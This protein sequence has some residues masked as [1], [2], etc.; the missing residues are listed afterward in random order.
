M[1]AIISGIE[2]IAMQLAYKYLNLDLSK[3]QLKIIKHPLSQAII[4]LFMFYLTC[5]NIWIS[6]LLVLGYQL[7]I[8]ILLNE[9]H[10]LN[11]YSKHWLIK[12]GFKKED[13]VQKIKENYK[14]NT[15]VLKKNT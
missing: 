9:T 7:V 3:A 6:V 4:L 11:V 8:N 12:E 5:N 2:M 10:P 14:V 1:Y 13:T 15:N